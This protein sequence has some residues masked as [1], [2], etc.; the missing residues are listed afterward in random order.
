[1]AAPGSARRQPLLLLLLAGLVHSA[2]AVFVVKDGNGTACIMANFSAAFLTK[3][4][5]N[6]GSKNVTFD[7]PSDA[8]VL[9]SSSCGKENMSNPSLMIA[10]GKGHKLT[11]SFTRNATRYSVQMMSFVYNLSDTEI[12]PNASSKEIRTAE[13]ITDIMADINKKYRCVSSNWIHMKNVTV[14]FSDTVIQAYLSNNSFSKEETRCK[15]DEPSPTGFPDRRQQVRVCGR[16]PAGREQHADP[17]RRGRRPS[18]TGPHRP[19]RL[20]HRQKEEPRRLPD[21][22]ATI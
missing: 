3:Y 5:T 14:T 12:F 21:Y 16:V 9:N 10:F 4:D 2:S 6:S 17:H 8:G 22:L 15:Q 18:G 1:M 7:L 11:L 19:H 20:P 13:S